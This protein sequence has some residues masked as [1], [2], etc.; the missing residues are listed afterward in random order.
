MQDIINFRYIAGYIDGDGCFYVGKYIKNSITIYEASIQILSVRKPV[1]DFFKSIYGGT[2]RQKQKIG[3]HKLAY[4]WTIKGYKSLHL[5]ENICS[6]LTDKFFVCQSFID[7][8]KSIKP[9]NFNQVSDSVI[10]FREQQIKKI[11]KDRHMDN[12]VTN[13]FVQ[14]LKTIS[15]TITPVKEDFIYFAGL[16][17]AEG[18]FRIKKWKPKSKPNNVYAICLEVGNTKIPI[19]AW[20]VE[21][22]GGSVS[23]IPS[24][25]KK[26][27]SATWS[28]SS[29]ALFEILHEL[30]PYLRS[31]KHICEKLIEF[32]STIIP[33]GGDRHSELFQN[34][35]S[36]TLARREAIVNEIH[37]FNSKGS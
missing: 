4:I 37:A 1:L 13:N 34:L 18:C 28:L 6:F 26:K 17:D 29:R 7:Y 15:K 5:A 31:K 14:S 22:F 36:K 12:F 11:R 20:L 8:I 25:G 21:R 32:Q 16:V 3:N 30:Q 27:A 2:I 19:L 10:N 33:N 24:K 23:F 9:N 35:F